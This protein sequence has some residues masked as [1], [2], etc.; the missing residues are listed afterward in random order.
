MQSFTQLI[1]K[2]GFEQK[3]MKEYFMKKNTPDASRTAIQETYK[4]MTYGIQFLCSSQR[5]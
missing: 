4:T 3:G 1:Q 2:G 5:K